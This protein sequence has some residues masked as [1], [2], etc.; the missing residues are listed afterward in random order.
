MAAFGLVFVPS[1]IAYRMGPS[2]KTSV[3][4]AAGFSLGAYLVAF[5]AAL[6]FDQPFGPVLVITLAA[7]AV[8]VWLVLLAL[9][10]RAP[11]SVTVSS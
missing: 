4:I 1:M 9:Q 3:I 6:L 10:R 7:L 5:A 11:T 2:W 8:S